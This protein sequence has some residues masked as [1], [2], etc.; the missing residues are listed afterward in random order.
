M[1]GR[2]YLD[3]GG[4]TVYSRSLI[5]AFSD[6][7]IANL[8]GN[9]HSASDPAKLSGHVVDSIR[10]KALH[11]F[12]ADPERF[13]LVF[14][15][16]ATAAIKLVA[17]SFRDLAS[18][19]S[20]S[21]T[22]WYGYHKDA[23]TSIV[24]VRELINGNHHC[25]GNDQEVEEWL[26]GYPTHFS[27]SNDSALPGLFAY[28]GQSNMTGRRLPLQWTGQLRQS[29]K[30]HHQNTYSLL[31][32]AALA[33]TTQL[34][35]SD[36]DT[37]PDFTALSFYKIFGF[38]DLGALIV[39]KK[40]G[41]IL[42]WRRYFGGGTVNML[43]VFHEA[44]VQRKSDS[45]HEA[46]EDGTLPF[47]NIVALGCAIDAHKKLYGSMKAISRHTSFLGHRLY[48]RVSN[49]SHYNGRPACVIY[50]DVTDPHLYTDPTKQGATIAFNI[51]RA[52]GTTVRYSIV[53][54]LAND[55]NIYLRSGGLCNAGGIASHLKVE[56]WQFK[57]A[58]SAGHRCG[59]HGDSEIISGKPT[60]VVRASLGAMSTVRDV[61]TF[62]T[63]LYDTFIEH[64]GEELALPSKV[65]GESR[66]PFKN[67]VQNHCE[68]PS[69]DF[70]P[71]C[72]IA[73]RPSQQVTEK[74]STLSLKPKQTLRSKRFLFTRKSIDLNPVL[75]SEV[76]PGISEFSGSTLT[77]EDVELQEQAKKN[78]VMGLTEYKSGS[79][80]GKGSLRFWKGLNGSRVVAT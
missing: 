4:A 26:N 56:P 39:R 64:V 77:G 55:R 7:M 57:R 28:P 44:T 24:G 6:K 63:F 43:T 37:A 20:V 71:E 54:R 62:I 8:Y 5:E 65:V 15:A 32:A 21:G 72:R 34:D 1:T 51:V 48:T 33:T 35:F 23:H 45:L 13:D 70:D 42:S 61:D 50:N 2:I 80:K 75:P 16:N 9:P 76:S 19:S 41:H 60:G 12:K 11:F 73:P 69:F 47:H 58:W 67:E 10:D 25:F 40:S 79:G 14:V 52:D 53:E 59:D 30:V 17:E 78:M 3:H 18:A 31:D 38:P 68:E 22:F 36:P 29:T 46:L 66:I 27:S 74:A 49:L